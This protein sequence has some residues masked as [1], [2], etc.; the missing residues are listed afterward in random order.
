MALEQHP[1]HRDIFI[2][3][4][5]GVI[6]STIARRLAK[7][8]FRLHLASRSPKKL[9]PLEALLGYEAPQV[10]TYTLDL[11]SLASCDRALGA[12]FKKAKQPF[13]LICVAGGLGT[14]G[15]FADVH[16]KS[17][18]RTLNE[19]FLAHAFLIQSFIK[20]FRLSGGREGSIVTFSGAGL[21]S[22][23]SFANVS[24][25]ST[26]KAALTHLVEA[27]APEIHD[28][29][30]RINA[31]A[32]G[33]VVSRI[34]DEAIDAGARAG[35]FADGAR[36]IKKSGGV[37]PELT[38]D[39]VDFM[40][41]HSAREITGRLLSARFDLKTVEAGPD[42]VAR[43]PALYRLRRIDGELFSKPQ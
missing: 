41:S 16:F 11:A 2:T 21:G 39:L 35:S 43:D 12:F 20:R 38:A 31:V 25:Y 9:A 13:G 19:N 34:T 36:R 22:D 17:W 33:P 23:T 32:P 4:A 7:R 18:V 15:P 26:A 10:A 6:G 29:G 42:R 1:R 28:L 37:S 27:L 5:S 30:L 8:G 3:G 14:M 40:L 24:A